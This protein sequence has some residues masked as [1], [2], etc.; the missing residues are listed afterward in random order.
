MSEQYDPVVIEA[1]WAAPVA[2][3]QKNGELFELT[4]RT[5]SAFRWRE[6]IRSAWCGYRLMIPGKPDIHVS[7]VTRSTSSR[8]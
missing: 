8:S 3:C 6:S 7:Y 2:D 4:P 5:W 1:Y